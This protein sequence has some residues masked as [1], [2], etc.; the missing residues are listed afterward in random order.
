MPKKGFETMTIQ[1]WI[2]DR[3]KDAGAPNETPQSVIRRLLLHDL[4]KDKLQT[5][6]EEW[7]KK[8]D[9]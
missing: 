8:Y 7:R 1:S 4:G 2:V 6:Y 9:R 3:L 5:R